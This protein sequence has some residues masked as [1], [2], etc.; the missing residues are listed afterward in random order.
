MTLNHKNKVIIM[1]LG[2]KN[3]GNDISLAVHT[4]SLFFRMAAILN[5]Q[6]AAT[7]QV[8]YD[9]R[10]DFLFHLVVTYNIPKGRTSTLFRMTFM[11]YGT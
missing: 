5:F 1:F 9:A 7:V 10:V 4:I 3:M 11:V 8:Y 6:M 2:P